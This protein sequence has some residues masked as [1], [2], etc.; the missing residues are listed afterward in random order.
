VAD[1]EEPEFQVGY[2]KPPYQTRFKPGQSGNPAGRR[3]KTKATF[4]E[5]VDKELDRLIQVTEEGQ[6]RRMTMCEAIARQYANKAAKG[7]LRAIALLIKAFG[8]RKPQH[9]DGL[10]PILQ[11]LR[12]IHAAHEALR[13]KNSLPAGQSDSV[14]KAEGDDRESDDGQS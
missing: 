9:A 1:K 12:S 14:A 4:P 13:L 8:T 10:S 2:K 6:P 3:K 7:D 11:A 5:A